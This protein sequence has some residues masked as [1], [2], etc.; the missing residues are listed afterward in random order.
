[1]QKHELDEIDGLSMDFGNWRFNLR[2]SNTEPLL[3]MNLET[4]ADYAL[5]EQK[6]DELL[7]LINA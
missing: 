6:R 1:N 2:A 5:M 3:R 7:Q 4:R